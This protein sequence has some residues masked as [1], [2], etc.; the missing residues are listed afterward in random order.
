MDDG[1]E[2][3]P[4]S[5]EKV[6]S[7]ESVITVKLFFSSGHMFFILSSPTLI[8][9]AGKQ[10]GCNR[11]GNEQRPTIAALKIGRLLGPG[12]TNYSN[13]FFL[14]ARANRKV[15]YFVL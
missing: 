9:A 6:F 11:S 12:S 7:M 5:Q 1:A 2:R 4:T 10:R 14:T 13:C 8:T 15:V 3:L